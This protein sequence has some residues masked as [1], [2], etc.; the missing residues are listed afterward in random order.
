MSVTRCFICGK[1]KQK[2]D[3]EL[4]KLRE[5]LKEAE[6]RAKSQED[7]R[8]QALQQLQTSTEVGLSICKGIY[9][10]LKSD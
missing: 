5:A 10:S 3:T 4:C 7:E 1:E 6:A 8:N 2:V 9:Q